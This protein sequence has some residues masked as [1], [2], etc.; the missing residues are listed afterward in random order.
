MKQVL[1][2]RKMWTYGRVATVYVNEV[3]ST[4]ISVIN[5]EIS[6]SKYNRKWG[7]PIPRERYNTTN[8]SDLD[9]IEKF[10][11]EHGKYDKKRGCKVWKGGWKPS[12]DNPCL[13]FNLPMA[14]WLKDQGVELIEL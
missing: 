14:K 7:Y 5:N 6:T 11:E 13:S 9:K 12:K 2:S 8:L 1:V 3:T 10:V 4:T